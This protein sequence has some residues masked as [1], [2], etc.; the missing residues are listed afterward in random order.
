MYVIAFTSGT[1]LATATTT[2]VTV[3]LD[4]IPALFEGVAKGNEEL[5]LDKTCGSIFR[6]PGVYA[7]L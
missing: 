7:M 2:G 5:S 3:V 6:L 1:F 4:V